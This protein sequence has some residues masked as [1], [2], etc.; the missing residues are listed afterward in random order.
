MDEQNLPIAPEGLPEAENAASG[1]SADPEEAENFP[2]GSEAAP[3]EPDSLSDALDSAPNFAAPDEISVSAQLEALR[4]RYPR[5]N[6]VELAQNPLFI[7]FA[8]GCGNDFRSIYENFDQFIDE[9]RRAAEAAVPAAVRAT[10]AAGFSR[11]GSPLTPA[12]RRALTEWNR[13]CPQYRMSEQEYFRCLHA[14]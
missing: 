5:L 4:M 9:A 8:A 14:R 2:D 10:G 7:R 6:P 3:E 12:Q 1:I 13:D 11:P